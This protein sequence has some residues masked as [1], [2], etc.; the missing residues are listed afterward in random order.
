MKKILALF[1]VMLLACVAHAASSVSRTGYVYWTL[2]PVSQSSQYAFVMFASQADASSEKVYL[3]IGDTNQTVAYN[4]STYPTTTDLGGSFYSPVANDSGE[5]S[6]FLELY[7]VN[8]QIV[9]TSEAVTY[10]EL[11]NGG[12]VYEDMSVTGVTDPYHFAVSAVPEP[13]GGLLLVLG[14]CVLALRRKRTDVA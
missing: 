9:G 11:L 4:Q 2:D 3:T 8:G 7:D 6:Y 13:T 10:A 5:V 12:F 14:A 1:T